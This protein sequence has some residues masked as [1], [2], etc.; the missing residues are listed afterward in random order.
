MSYCE[1]PVFFFDDDYYYPHSFIPVWNQFLLDRDVERWDIF[2]TKHGI[3]IVADSKNWDH[4]QYLLDE[5]K[6]VFP[7]CDYIRN[8]RRLRLRIGPKYVEETGEIVSKEPMLRDCNC[9]GKH[10]EKRVGRLELYST[11][12]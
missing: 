5:T 2:Q 1:I 4:C 3:H 6:A 8:C 9:K 7:K 12:D 11:F 10:I